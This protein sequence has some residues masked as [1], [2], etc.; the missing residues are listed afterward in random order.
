MEKLCF[1]KFRNQQ[2]IYTVEINLNTQICKNISITIYDVF[3]SY[4]NKFYISHIYNT[5]NEHNKELKAYTA[6]PDNKCSIFKMN[7]EKNK[8]NC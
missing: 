3:K 2:L 6:C 1:L 7:R 8:K 5:E 4:A